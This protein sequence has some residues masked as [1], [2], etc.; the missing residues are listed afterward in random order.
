MANIMLNDISEGSIQERAW[1]DILF[2]LVLH[3][4]SKQELLES[5]YFQVKNDR[6]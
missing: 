5:V 1:I 2:T 4:L 6:S 3:V